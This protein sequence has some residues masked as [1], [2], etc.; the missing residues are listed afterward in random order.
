MRVPSFHMDHIFPRP[1]AEGLF[2]FVYLK[3]YPNRIVANS[4]DPLESFHS[5]DILAP[6]PSIPSAWKFVTRIDDRVTLLNGEKVLPLP[7]EG[8]IRQ[9]A[10]VREVVVFGIGKAFPGILL[11]RGDDAK[12]ESDE[13]F[14]DK[15]WPMIEEANKQ[16]ESF[17]KISKNMVVPL[18]PGT[19]IPQTDKGSVIRAQVYNVFG[20]EIENAYGRLDHQQEGSTILDTPALLEYLQGLGA[21]I[22]GK[23]LSDPDDDLFSLGMNS[24]QALEMRGAI[25]K[26]L[27]LGGNGK[28]LS[29]NVV[30]EQGNISNLARHL[31]NLRL[32][33]T[34]GKEKPI[35]LIKEMVTKYSV[36]ARPRKMID[37]PAEGNIIVSRAVRDLPKVTVLIF[38][39][40]D[41]HGRNRRLRGPSPHT[42]RQ[43]STN[44][45]HLLPSPRR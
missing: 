26:H 42:A 22:L 43:A 16:A 4:N 32:G 31:D 3:D 5:K 33:A 29:Q 41:S 24:L 45:T 10:L 37:R 9:H 28:K 39:C 27:N 20:N 2:E 44:L 34:T 8:H 35:S 21:E 18:P 36:T 23:P 25:L 38:I 17:S 15:V 11:F 1:V 13:D 14:I 7:I 19:N 12:D 30:F 6:H 40:S